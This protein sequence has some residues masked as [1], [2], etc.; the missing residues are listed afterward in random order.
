MK[1]FVP[2]LIIEEIST[3]D[4]DKLRKRNISG[5]LIDID[6]TIVPWGETKI[7]KGLKT[8]VKDAKEQGFVVCLVSNALKNRAEELGAILEVPVVGRAM[9]PMKRAFLKG[10]Q[11][12]DLPPQEV[13]FVG[14]QVLTDIFGANRLNLYSILVNP[15][16]TN[17]LGITKLVRKLET[18]ILKHFAKKGLVNAE[19]LHMRGKGE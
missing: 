4:L 11:M 2:D 13:A 17:E 15:L 19:L 14:D 16:S 18:K 1:V 3:I 10:L 7:Q 12:L 6:N 5:L 9:K 8:W